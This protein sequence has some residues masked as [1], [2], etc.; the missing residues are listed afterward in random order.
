[1]GG[2][3]GLLEQ[4]GISLTPAGE[5]RRIVAM[6][7]LLMLGFGPRLGTAVNEL[8]IKLHPE[9]EAT[10]ASVSQE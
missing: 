2:V 10:S 1:V 7:D 5:N 9:L 8:T 3:D 4:P 6:D